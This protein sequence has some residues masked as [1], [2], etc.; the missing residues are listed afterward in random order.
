MD[1]ALQKAV[2]LSCD[3]EGKGED[4]AKL[5]IAWFDEL[6]SKVTTVD[7]EVQTSKRIEFIFDNLE[8]D[9]E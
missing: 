8:V 5:I 9:D 6:A 4:F 7:D 2:I 3:E 1:D